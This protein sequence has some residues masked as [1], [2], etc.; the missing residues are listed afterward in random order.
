MAESASLTEHI[1]TLNTLFAQLTSLG[2]KIEVGEHVEILLQSVLDS[3]DQLII[4]LTNN[5]LTKYL[6]FDDVVVAVHEEESRCKS[7]EDK[8]A[9]TL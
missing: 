1:N 6:V 9:T 5:I 2:H 4:N 8:L 7:E 3:Y